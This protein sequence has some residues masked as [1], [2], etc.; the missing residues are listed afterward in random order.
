M[1]GD[2]IRQELA[3]RWTRIMSSGLGKEG[4]EHILQKYPTPN[5]FPSAVAPV[6]NPEILASVSELTLKRDRR[7]IHRQNMTGKL[8]TC[9]GKSL[10][11]LL[12]GNI[13]TKMLVEEINDAAKLAAEVFHQDSSSRKFFALA[14][15][16]QIVKEAVRNTKTDEFLFG[17][18]CAEKIKAAQAIQK[19]GSQ[20][21][22]DNSATT[23]LKK[24]IPSARKQENWKGPPPAQFQQHQRSRGGHRQQPLR[25]NFNQHHHKNQKRLQ[26]R[27]RTSFRR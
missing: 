27:S 11:S 25:R 16:N 20:I 22:T 24:S 4:R 21:K 8:M 13:N 26:P 14:G 2:A 18:D 23:K 15:A 3:L 19:T 5:N 7:I 6:L 1:V 9:L 12:K 10:T 17:K